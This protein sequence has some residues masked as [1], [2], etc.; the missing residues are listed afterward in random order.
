MEAA[1]KKYQKNVLDH[2]SAAIQC[3][4]F[5]EK[6]IFMMNHVKQY[7]KDFKAG[8]ALTELVQKRRTMLN[9][10]IRSDYHRYKWVCVDYGIPDV[11]PKN[12]HHKESWGRQFNQIS[13]Y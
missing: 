7:P 12:A 3:A 1:V 13:G 11:H 5:S 9:Y 2:G 8:R 10:C 6:I 4:I